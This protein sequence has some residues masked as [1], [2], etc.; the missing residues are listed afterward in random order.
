M[1]LLPNFLRCP[2]WDTSFKF[3]PSGH[4]LYMREKLSDISYMGYLSV[5]L[6]QT[7]FYEFRIFCLF[8]FEYFFLS[9]K[10]I[11][12]YTHKCHYNSLLKKKTTL[13]WR[14]WNLGLV[15]LVVWWAERDSNFYLFSRIFIIRLEVCLMWWLKHLSSP[16]TKLNG[17]GILSIHYCQVRLVL[18]LSTFY[19]AFDLINF[20]RKKIKVSKILTTLCPFHTYSTV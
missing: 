8:T 4:R 6:Q 12:K 15:K 18:E 17:I 20:C 7:L 11:S 2:T 16:V 5:I 13:D 10:L 3:F 1:P 19:F 14:D 9:F